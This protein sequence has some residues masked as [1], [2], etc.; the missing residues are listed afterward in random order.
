[1]LLTIIFLLS[2]CI[3]FICYF[4][5][6]W[7]TRLSNCIEKIYKNVK[8]NDLKRQIQN[9]ICKDIDTYINK[10][11]QSNT[12]IG[13]KKY[14]LFPIEYPHLYKLY[15]QAVS[16]IWNSNDINYTEDI[17]DWNTKITDDE[18]H[19]LEHVLAFFASSDGIVN[20]NLVVN[21]FRD[22]KISEAEAFY[23]VQIFMEM[24]HSETY[25]KILQTL[26]NNETKKENLFKALETIPTIEQKANWCNQW[27]CPGNKFTN[28]PIYSII[29]KQQQHKR[30]AHDNDRFFY[31]NNDEYPFE[32]R[33]IAFVCVEGI[34]FSSSFAAIYWMKSRGLLPALCTA[35][36]YIARDESLHALFATELYKTKCDETPAKRI[37]TCI[38]HDMFRSACEIEVNFI[39]NALPNKIDGMNCDL[40]KQH[41]EY[42]TDYWLKKLGYPLLYNVE[43]PF[44][45]MKQIAVNSKENFFEIVATNYKSIGIYKQE[46]LNDNNDDDN[47]W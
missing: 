22:V 1:M 2:T 18:R 47:N 17:H 30:H 12:A 44:D 7:F 20:E 27:M 38:V 9:T 19:F 26:V 36:E 41:V 33:L 39:N 43:C 23:S 3:F 10:P 25:S 21:F 14:T 28:I 11:Q 31:L 35:N 34:F 5:F 32:Q 37:D 46:Q 45:F 29:L 15:E 24:I 16:S 4:E 42:V 8:S 13:K 40:M 6:C